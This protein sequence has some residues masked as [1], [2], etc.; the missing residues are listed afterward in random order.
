MLRQPTNVTI[1]HDA[2]KDRS[3][4]LHSKTILARMKQVLQQPR[5]GAIT[6]AEVP[7]PIA[8][9]GCVLVRI[10]ASVVSSG[11]ERASSDFAS[12]NLLQKAKA[13]PD[14]AREVLTKLR[15][16]G[17]FPTIAAVRNRL[18]QPTA[19]GYSCAGT[20]VGVGQGITDVAIGD[21]VACSGAG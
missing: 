11:T 4:P 20:I 14:L 15:R 7:A 8:Q 13:R 10:A 2:E 19:L 3:S 17:L 5:G 1:Q 6:V 18:D 9:P 21:H 12:K 16:D